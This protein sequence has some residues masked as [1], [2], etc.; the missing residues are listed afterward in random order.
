MG[1]GNSRMMLEND[2]SN[3]MKTSL[4]NHVK[5]LNDTNFEVSES[6]NTENINDSGT[7]IGQTNE[8]TMENITITDDCS[9]NITQVNEAS[10]KLVSQTA[11]TN[12]ATIRND[13]GLELQNRLAQQLSQDAEFSAQQTA[14]TTM[15]QAEQNNGGLDGVAAKFSD[16][17]V[18]ALGGKNNEQSVVNK[19]RNEFQM[20]QDNLTEMINK[21]SQHF[22]KQYNTGQYTKCMSNIEQD[23][24]S[25]IYNLTCSGNASVTILQQNMADSNTE[26]FSE[27]FNLT[28]QST[29]TN[30]KSGQ[31]V[32]TIIDQVAA[33][34]VIQKA[35]N[36]LKQTRLQKNLLDSIFGNLEGIIMIAIIG[37]IA[38]VVVVLKMGAGGEGSKELYKTWRILI[39]C[40]VL[41][42]IIILVITF[43]KEREDSKNAVEEEEEKTLP[44]E[45]AT[46]CLLT[47]EQEEEY[48]IIELEII[49][50]KIQKIN[51]KYDLNL[52]LNN[53]TSEELEEMQRS[54]EEDVLDQLDL[55]KSTCATEDS[56]GTQPTRPDVYFTIKGCRLTPD[57]RRDYNRLEREMIDDYIIDN[58]KEIQDRIVEIQNST[59]EGLPQTRKSSLIE[60]L[61]GQKLISRSKL[62]EE[63]LGGVTT[64][65]TTSSGTT[66]S[67]TT[68][69]DVT[70]SSAGIT[71]SGTNAT[72]SGI[73]NC[74]LN[75]L[76]KEF[77]DQ[78][79]VQLG[80]NCVKSD[81]ETTAAV[82]TSDVTSGAVTTTSNG[83]N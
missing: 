16:N 66:S 77:H 35:E 4:K 55:D 37:L 45:I 67:G 79:M 19:L 57:Q 39:Y 62:A 5:S 25:K 48:K 46:N 24:L 3:I 65:G 70:T 14:Q 74:R 32:E 41:V 81:S 60:E 72:T 28:D 9:I 73:V 15:E 83:T 12:N 43:V 36:E 53:F 38:I 34:E 82:T 54:V 1:G 42:V 7:Y 23:N 49:S 18:A 30:V 56:D 20:D 22:E 10:S 52:T 27:F 61:E 69:S 40:I 33:L 8:L 71:S 11:F 21:V 31:D 78:I 50:K 76:R 80:I 58:D 68:S 63:C 26:C 2:L 6:M 75:D 44:E 17:M 29:T 64:S 13:Y 51:E 59:L 47:P